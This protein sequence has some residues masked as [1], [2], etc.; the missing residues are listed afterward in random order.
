MVPRGNLSTTYKSGTA[1]EERTGRG[2]GELARKRLQQKGTMGQTTGEL[3]E[4]VASGNEKGKDEGQ[5]GV[6][7]LTTLSL[8]PQT[9]I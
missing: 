9:C 7:V 8:A 2:N 1:C 6:T 5:C 4:K 3:D